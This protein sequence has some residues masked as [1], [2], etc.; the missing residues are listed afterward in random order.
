MDTDVI[1]GRLQ[2]ERGRLEQLRDGLREDSQAGPG[3]EGVSELSSVDQHPADIGTEEFER[4]K[5]LS[6]LEQIEEELAAVDNAFARLESGEYG[7]CEVCGKPIGDERLEAR[8]TANR[9]IE[10]QELLERESRA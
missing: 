1:R 10:H 4:E 6:I 7:R 3:G 9:C 5:D 8:P 2:E